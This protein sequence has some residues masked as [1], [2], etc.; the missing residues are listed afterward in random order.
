MRLEELKNEFPDI[1][2]FV[3]D[4][5]REEVEKQISVSNSIRMKKKRSSTDA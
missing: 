3:H 5:I 1:P 2:D 4:M